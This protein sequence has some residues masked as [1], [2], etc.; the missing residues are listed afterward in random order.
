[1]SGSDLAFMMSGAKQ[2]AD[3]LKNLDRF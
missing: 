1:L 3:Y 2:R